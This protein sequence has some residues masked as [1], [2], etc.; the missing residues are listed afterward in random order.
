MLFDESLE[1]LMISPEGVYF[2]GTF[3]RGGHSNGILQKLG[4]SGRLYSMD[5]DPQAAKV[6]EEIEDTRLVFRQGAFS[7]FDV[8]FPDMLANSVDGVLLDLGVSSPQLDQAERG[9]SFRREGE[10]DMRMDPTTG[11]TAKEFVNNAE[12][13]ELA[14]VIARLGEERF[15]KKIAREIITARNLATITTTTDLAEIVKRA[16]PVRFHVEGRHPATRTFQAIRIHVNNELGEL[17]IFLGKIFSVL[18]HGGRIVII[19]FHSLE[20]KVV[21]QFV[22]KHSSDDLPPEIPVRDASL[23]KKL[24][25]IGRPVRPSEVEINANPRSR[26]SIMR[27]V[28]KL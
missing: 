17:E 28:E 4:E 16:I 13:G 18:K 27:I 9:F 20:D 19:S 25:L 5:R 1:A 15:A 3:G 22:K 23:F 21:K 12:I 14:N 2:D 8:L 10:L 24:K 6:A 26:S 11:F 7:Q